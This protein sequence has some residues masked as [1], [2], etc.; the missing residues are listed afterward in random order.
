MMSRVSVTVGDGR[1]ASAVRAV[2]HALVEAFA[3]CVR[4][5]GVQ[6]TSLDDVARVAGVSRA[7]V[8]R[9]F[10]GGK[11]A[12]VDALVAHERGQLVADVTEAVT[13]AAG[14]E[15][16]LVAGIV[17]VGRWFVEHDVVGTTIEHEPELMLPYLAFGGLDRVLA[18][19]AELVADLLGDDLGPTHRLGVADWLCRLVLSHLLAPSAFVDLA[20]PESVRRFVRIFILP[21]LERLSARSAHP[22]AKEPA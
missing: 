7:T 11:D 1:N 5:F 19:A 6:R 13:A 20:D 10:P 12:L 18:P 21:A 4:R 17:A 2:D 8:Y 9:A 3:V 15:D 14:L 16:R 22:L